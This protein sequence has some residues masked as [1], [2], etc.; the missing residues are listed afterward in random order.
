[1]DKARTPTAGSKYRTVLA[2]FGLTLCISIVAGLSW[3]LLQEID[4]VSTA[5]SDNLEFTLAQSDVE[6]AHFRLAIE[7]AVQRKAEIATV[8]RRFDIFYSRIDTLSRG[9]F[10]RRIGA[11]ADFQAPLERIRSFLDA[12]VPLIDGAD[13][14]LRAALPPLAEQ[15][16]IRAADV[17]ALTLAGLANSSQL[18]DERRVGLL[19]T[20]IAISSVLGLLVAGLGLLALKLLHLARL[21]EVQTRAVQDAAKQLQ[22]IVD[23]A[24]DAII[25][26]DPA[27]RIREFNPAATR[28]FDRPRDQA[29][30]RTIFDIVLPED[31]HDALRDAGTALLAGQRQALTA[32]RRLET[33][34]IDAAGRRFPVE[35]SLDVADARGGRVFVAY[36]RDISR[37][38]ADEAALTEAR[39]KALAGE[40][41]KAEF[42]AITSHEMRTPLNGMLGTM[43]LLQ[44]EDLPPRQAELLERMHNSGQMLLGLANDVLDLAKY[45]AGKL[46]AERGSFALPPLLDGILSTAA[47]MATANGNHMAWHWLGAPRDIVQGDPRRLRQVLLNLVGNAVKFTRGGKITI[48]AQR[49]EGPGDRVIFRVSDTGIGIA[50]D[51]IERIFR[52]FETLDSSYARKADGT[53][54]GLGIARRLSDLM[55]GQIT[56]ESVLGKGSTFS[57]CLPLPAGQLADTPAT[58]A[59]IGVSKAAPMDLLV[60]EDNEVNRFV[61]RKMLHAMGHRVTEATDGRAGVEMAISRRFDA[62]L[63]DISM[64]VMDGTEAAQRIRAAGGGSYRAPIIAVTAH[65]LPEETARFRDIGMDHCISKPISRSTLTRTLAQLPAPRPAAPPAPLA[66]LDKAVLADLDDAMPTE[67]RDR[68]IARFLQDTGAE[69]RVLAAL[70]PDVPDLRA[71]IH[72]CAG[73]CGTFGF[74]AMGQS[75]RDI[76]SKLKRGEAVS[77]ANLAALP[78][79]WAESAAALAASH[80]HAAEAP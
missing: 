52:D 18:A 53:G 8:R 2:V 3:R 40:R 28:I 61:L 45:E 60:V 76:E 9:A 25:V 68:L 49:A 64:P 58:P 6:F 27:G 37:R 77:P 47:P 48:T 7:K 57:L 79:L 15:A 20:L 31:S 75:L 19:R 30:G 29:I 36:I 55:G 13:D 4:D 74:A 17:R 56:A 38:K 33:T 73:S 26:T 11:S 51:D 70:D 50:P 39:D 32:E 72:N 67:E 43:E 42:L 10:Y 69:I 12:T 41:A 62:I 21:A 65:A 14:T 80:G 23:T 35:I 54:L 46:Q 22:I 71:R 59:P 66:L 78:K 24:L 1:V 44:D 63:M 5:N 34:A 16:E